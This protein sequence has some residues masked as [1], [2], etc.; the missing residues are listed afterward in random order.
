[1][2]IWGTVISAALPAAIQLVGGLASQSA[3]SDRQDEADARADARHSDSLAVQQEGLAVSR[4]RI[5][6]QKA[7]AEMQAALEREA[8]KKNQAFRFA[9]TIGDSADREVRAVDNIVKAYQRSL[10]ARV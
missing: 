10:G 5:A 9:S 2:S 4:E 8:Q 7:I 1:M 3:A 6:A